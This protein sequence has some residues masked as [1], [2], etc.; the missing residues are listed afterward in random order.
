MAKT[1]SKE[2][3]KVFIEFWEWSELHYPAISKALQRIDRARANLVAAQ[4]NLVALLREMNNE[5]AH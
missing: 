1:T 5:Y 3:D 2:R 4:N